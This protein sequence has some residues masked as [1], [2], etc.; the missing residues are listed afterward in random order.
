MAAL[1]M[2]GLLRSLY[3]KQRVNSKVVHVI[4]PATTSLFTM[5]TLTGCCIFLIG[6]F[7]TIFNTVISRVKYPVSKIK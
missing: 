6:W 7:L 4:E 1:V 3:I 5:I 2:A